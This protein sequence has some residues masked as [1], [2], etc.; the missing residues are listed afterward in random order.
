LL[1][2]KNLLAKDHQNQGYLLT[3]TQ[4]PNQFN[5]MTN[6]KK[7]LKHMFHYLLLI[8]LASFISNQVISKEVSQKN[9]YDVV[10]ISGAPAGVAAAIAASRLGKSVIIIEQSPVLGGMLSSGVLRLDDHMVQANSG[11]MEEFR[12]RI[13]K[14]HRDELSDDPVVKMHM[15]Q[16]TIRWNTAEGQAWEPSTAASVYSEMVAEYPSI[17]TRFNEV[18]IDVI[19]KGNRVVGVVTRERDNQGNLGAKSSYRGKVIIDAT[20]EAD[21]AEFAGIPYRIGREARSREEPHAG[22]IYTDAFGSIPGTLKGTI[23]PGSTGEADNRSQAFTYRLTGKDYHTPDHAFRL[24]EPPKDYD[25]EKYKWNSNQKPII[26]N[27]KFDLLGINYGA[28]LTGY[29]TRFVLADWQERKEIEEVFRNHSLGWLYYI[30]TE[31]GSPNVGLADDEFTDNQN[32]PYRLYVRQGRRIEGLYRLTESDLHK[33]LR[34]DGVRGPLHSESVAIGMYPIDSHNVQGPGSRDAGP[35]GED[36][37]E[38]DLHLED[39]TGPYQIP[40]G[41]MVPKNVNGLLFPVGISSTHLAISSVRM[42]PVWSSLGQAAG[43]AASLSI[44]S[45]I[46]LSELPV[47]EIQDIL[48]DQGSYLFFYQDLPAQEPA[49]EAA[50]KLSLEGAIDGDENYFF[51]PNQP[52]TLGE[53]ARLVVKGFQLPISITAAHFVDVPRGHP[54]FK[55]IETLYDYSTQSPNPFFEYELRNY[56][57]YW[58]GDQA[59]SGPPA[60]AYPEQA[61]TVN[62]AVRIIS[63]LLGDSIN[64]P[65][66]PGHNMTRS[67]AAMLVY[68]LVKQHSN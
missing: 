22:V 40:Y 36:A 53:F 11:I 25:P 56:L 27:G 8:L 47:S 10:V 60:F 66:Q 63:G 54:E 17:T 67:E 68:D 50:Q 31:G 26:P 42:E 39:V 15:Q 13:S 45:A 19:L 59:G 38:G 65:D 49:F 33:D 52:I 34:G 51:H 12:K 48:I 28:D 9:Q 1:I 57:N 43:I 3:N 4:I 58:W 16:P 32:L 62:V 24:L 23:F 14:Y 18:A 44:D 30:Q 64:A 6:Q 20:Y 35:F 61:V 29:S 2:S 41:V 5:R 37:A 21:L 7:S 55:Y 46:E